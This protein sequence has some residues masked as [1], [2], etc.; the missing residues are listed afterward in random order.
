[1][2]LPHKAS[3][4][5]C[6]ILLHF[7]WCLFLLCFQ[8]DFGNLFW[9]DPNQFGQVKIRFFWTNFYNLYL[10]KMILTQPKRPNENN[11]DGQKSF[12]T[13]VRTMHNTAQIWDH[14]T[15]GHFPGLRLAKH[16]AD[17]QDHSYIFP[18]LLFLFYLT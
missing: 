6:G 8:N 3:S 10:S 11:L 2:L 5:C 9:S 1:M 15:Q 7:S 13:Y 4:W 18:W 17:S 16:S 12:W 14:K